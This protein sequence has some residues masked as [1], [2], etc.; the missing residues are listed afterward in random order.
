MASN[1]DCT[2]DFCTYNEAIE[3]SN[4]NNGILKY[5]TPIQIK[6]GNLIIKGMFGNNSGETYGFFE[7]DMIQNK[8]SNKEITYPKTNTFVKIKIMPSKN[9]PSYSGGKKIKSRKIKQRKNI[10]KQTKCR[11][12]IQKDNTRKRNNIKRKCIYR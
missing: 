4:K 8:Y 2:K 7:F 5:H 3:Y 1:L 12:I 10:K 11:K 6:N 9:E